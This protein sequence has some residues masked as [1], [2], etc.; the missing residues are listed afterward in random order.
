MGT[1]PEVKLTFDIDGK[2][3]TIHKRFAGQA[4]KATLTCSDQRLFEDDA[5]EARTGNACSVL[6]AAG[7]AVK[8]W[9]SG[10][11]FGFNRGAN[12]FRGWSVG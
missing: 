6:R 1:V 8:P 7:V 5:A 12:S 9:A 10:E 11:P 4:G 3:W 2:T